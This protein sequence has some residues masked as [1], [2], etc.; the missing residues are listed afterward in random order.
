M[1][2]SFLQQAEHRAAEVK[3]VID[4]SVLLFKNEITCSCG[5]G[6]AKDGRCLVLEALWCQPHEV[7]SVSLC[8]LVQSVAGCAVCSEAVPLGTAQLLLL[9]LI[10]EWDCPARVGAVMEGGWWAQC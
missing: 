8:L 1:R 9:I 7:P 5:E 3:V 2:Q 4:Q 10:W 6:G